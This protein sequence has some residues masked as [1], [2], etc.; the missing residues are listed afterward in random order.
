M[1]VAVAI[2]REAGREKV[3]ESEETCLLA[4]CRS[5]DREA[6][7]ALVQRY[8]E[9]TYRLAFNL[10]GNHEE[11]LDACQEALIAMLRSLH[12]FRGEAR[13]Q[14]WLC[15][16]TTNVCLMQRRRLQ[17]RTRIFAGLAAETEQRLGRRPDPESS[18]L[19]LEVQSAVRQHLRALP[20]EFR[21]VVVLR[22]MEGLSY[23][24]IAEVLQIP[25]GT[26]QSRL[27]RGRSLLREAMLADE[28][29]PAPRG[30]REKR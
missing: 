22:E 20:N 29:I 5:G 10:L 21:A 9:K 28:R 15:R 30:R 4:R 14:T 12:T 6:Q 8:Q 25:L 2:C 23:E 26:V 3:A 16:L 17:V 7:E 13:F 18:A 27:S 24:E 11:A 19:S 1:S